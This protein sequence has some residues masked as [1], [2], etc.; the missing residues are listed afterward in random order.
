MSI[1]FPSNPVQGQ[2]YT[3]N[4]S[5]WIYNGYAWVAITQE[6]VPVPT[7]DSIIYAIIFG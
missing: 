5:N 1:D 3:F 2:V 7:E 4:N 6:S